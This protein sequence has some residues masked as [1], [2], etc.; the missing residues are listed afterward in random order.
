VA[1]IEIDGRRYIMGAYGSV[2]WVRN[3]RAAGEAVLRIHGKDERVTA[4]ELDPG[5][6]ISFYSDTL[7]GYIRNFP[8]YGRAFAKVFFGLVGPELANDPE[9]AAELHPVFELESA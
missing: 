2:N 9:R 3:L 8:W 7:P 6:A 4:R 1:V 5:A